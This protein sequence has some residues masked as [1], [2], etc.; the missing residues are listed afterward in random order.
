MH[1][2]LISLSAI[3]QGRI[4]TLQYGQRHVDQMSTTHL[5]YLLTGEIT[6]W[7][8]KLITYLSDPHNTEDP[9]PYS[10]SYSAGG[11]EI[12]EQELAQIT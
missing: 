10:E 3:Y 11:T 4:P 1:M 6:P 8:D 2:L 12:P 9:E 7:I 5:R